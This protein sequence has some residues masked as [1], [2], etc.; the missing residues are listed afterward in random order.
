MDERSFD[1]ACR[2]PKDGHILQRGPF[3]MDTQ[4]QTFSLHGEPVD[5][6]PCAFACLEALMRRAP[7]PVSYDQLAVESLGIKL[8]QLEAQDYCRWRILRLREAIELNP[9]KP[10]YI[11]TVPGWGY[12]LQY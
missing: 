8:G 9:V 11:V 12:R 7:Q 10:I 1:R 3:W 2:K 4:N 5:L 6:P